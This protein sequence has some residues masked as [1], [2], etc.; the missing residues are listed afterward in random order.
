MNDG[1][2][3]SH[4]DRIEMPDP[5]AI[6]DF[7]DDFLLFVHAARRHQDDDILAL[8]LLSRISVNPLRARVPGLN[9]AVKVFADDGVLRGIHD[10]GKLRVGA[11]RCLPLRNFAGG[12]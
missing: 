10:G 5:D 1:P 12:V 9:P 6:P 8:D 2:I 11:F 7:L 3:F 4:S